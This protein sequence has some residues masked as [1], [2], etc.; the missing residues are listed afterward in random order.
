MPEKAKTDEQ[1]ADFLQKI[2]YKLSESCKRC[3]VL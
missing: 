1:L 2:L 3:G